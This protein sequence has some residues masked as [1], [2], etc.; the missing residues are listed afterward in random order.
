MNLQHHDNQKNDTNST[1]EEP[2]SEFKVNLLFNNNQQKEDYLKV[3]SDSEA[4]ANKDIESESNLKEMPRPKS[5]FAKILSRMKE[6]QSKPQA[7]DDTDKHEDKILDQN[8]EYVIK[9]LLR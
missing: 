8:K 1:P 5:T 9:S 4:D 6:T 3:H 7:E 2:I